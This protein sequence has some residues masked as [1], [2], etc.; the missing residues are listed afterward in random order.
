MRSVS[1]A[2]GSS[3]QG[4]PPSSAMTSARSELQ[5]LGMLAASSGWS[6][7]G[8]GAS[9]AVPPVGGTAD[10]TPCRGAGRRRPAST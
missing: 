1:A 10:G 2:T 9:V 6:S 3:R 5:M 8:S 4:T 7:C